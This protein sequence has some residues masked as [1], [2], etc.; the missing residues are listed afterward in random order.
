M[1]HI[2]GMIFPPGRAAGPQ[3]VTALIIA[4]AATGNY[5]RGDQWRDAHRLLIASALAAVLPV[6]VIMWTG[7]TSGVLLQYTLT[8][9]ALWLVLIAERFSMYSIVGKLLPASRGVPTLFVGTSEACRYAMDLRVFRDRGGYC[10]LGFVDS[11]TPIHPSARGPVNQFRDLLQE[12]RAEVVV[13]CGYVDDA[14][15]RDVADASMA[16]G[17]QILSVQR[18]REIA[19]VVP[20]I[21]VRDGEPLVELTAPTLRGRQLFVKRI[22]DIAGAIVGLTLLGIPMLLIALA[23]KLDSPGPVLFSQERVGLGGR[24]FRMLKFRTMRTGAETERDRLAHLNR[25]G[26]IRLFKIPNDPRVTQVGQLLRRASLDELPQLWNV[27]VG[28][29]SLVGPRPFFESD[30]VAYQDHHLR[31]LGAKPGIT[32]LWQV[33]GRSDVTD[34]EEVVRLDREYIERWSVGLDLQI[35]IMT[36]PAVLTRSGAF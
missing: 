25:S 13:I 22:I 4:L 9:V 18:G 28:V 5:A 17:T 8:T 33:T 24:R 3:F 35:L 15:F 23:V 31:R 11:Q 20:R 10:G 26:D 32:G 7:Y 16:A 34:F 27:L 36:V 21:M 29:M 19:G 30:L 14:T 6:W 2:A 12:S 1:G